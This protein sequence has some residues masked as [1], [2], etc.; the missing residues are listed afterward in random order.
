MT[1]KTAF[2]EG[3]SWFKFNNLG[4]A[5]CMNLKFYTSLSKGLKLKVKKFLGLILTF[6]EVTGENLVGGACLTPPP[7]SILNRVKIIIKNGHYFI[8]NSKCSQK[9]LNEVF[10]SSG[11]RLN[12]THREKLC[13][14]QFSTKITEIGAWLPLTLFMFIQSVKFYTLLCVNDTDVW[15]RW[16][17]K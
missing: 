6:V 1:R 16:L 11:V 9:T 2:L 8:Y 10:K 12:D 4:L 7:P 15:T 14:T 5:L 17:I 3:W 13:F